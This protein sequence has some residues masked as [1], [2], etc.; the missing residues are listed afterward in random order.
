[1]GRREDR[2]L[3]INSLLIAVLRRKPKSTVMVHSDQGG[4]FSS[5][6]W[7]AFLKAPNL[8][9]SMRRRS[10]C[11]DI[12]IAKSFSQLFKRERICPKTNAIRDEARQ[13]IFF[14]YI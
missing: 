14:D 2:D 9:P 5:Y 6:D 11:R 13:D 1:M 10:N 3:A 4:E 8:Q 12:A 7:D